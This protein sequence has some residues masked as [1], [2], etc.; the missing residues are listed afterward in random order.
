M[1]TC[2]SIS[3]Q[4]SK[5]LELQAFGAPQFVAI[6]QCSLADQGP[7]LWLARGKCMETILS[8]MLVMGRRNLGVSSWPLSPLPKAVSYG[9]CLQNTTSL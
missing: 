7:D 2:S 6:K 9:A 4:S 1:S 8:L 3:H 5:L